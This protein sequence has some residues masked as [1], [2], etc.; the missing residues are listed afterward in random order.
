VTRDDALLGEV[1]W[2]PG[3]RE[4][5]PFDAEFWHIVDGQLNP[6]QAPVCR[7]CYSEQRA[8]RR[9][10]VM[11]VTRADRRLPESIPGRC[12]ARMRSAGR[13]GRRADHRNSHRSIEAMAE[14]RAATRE[15][16]VKRDAA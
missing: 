5:W 7:A 3:C 8:A 12:N 2:C 13:C 9:R 14:D 16:R 15:W 1:L 4:D 11:T 10:L 6:R